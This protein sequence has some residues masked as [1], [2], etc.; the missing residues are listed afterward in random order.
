MYDIRFCECEHHNALCRRISIT[1]CTFCRFKHDLALSLKTIRDRLA[2]ERPSVN[3]MENLR[4]DIIE[5]VDLFQSL[6]G[7]EVH[8]I[9]EYAELYRLFCLCIEVAGNVNF[10]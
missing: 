3:A 10:D 5:A 7:I 9:K 1:E 2:F 4:L 6:E 8:L